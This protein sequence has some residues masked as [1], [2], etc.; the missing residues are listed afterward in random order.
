MPLWDNGLTS[1]SESMPIRGVDKETKCVI[2]NKR[3]VIILNPFYTI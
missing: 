1:I 2:Q 3:R